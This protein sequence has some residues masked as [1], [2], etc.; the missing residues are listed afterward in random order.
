MLKLVLFIYGVKDISI[1]YLGVF[2][3]FTK[4]LFCLDVCTSLFRFILFVLI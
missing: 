1:I 4:D 3:K 2:C